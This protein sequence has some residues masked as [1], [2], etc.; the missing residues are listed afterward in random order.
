MPEILA[1][2]ATLGRN[3]VYAGDHPPAHVFPLLAELVREHRATL[4]L[5][6]VGHVLTSADINA[7]LDW[8]EAD[9]G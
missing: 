8:K 9:S 2:L 3:R 4:G 1:W 6:V 7:A 5:T